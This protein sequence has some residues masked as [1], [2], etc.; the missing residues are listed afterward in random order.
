MLCR[1]VSAVYRDFPYPL[2]H[3]TGLLSLKKNI[4]EVDLKTLIGG[5]PLSLAGTIRNPGPNAIVELD[6]QAES[7]PVDDT[8]KKAVRPEVRKVLDQFN[9]SG[10]VKAHATVL[11]TPGQGAQGS[12]KDRSGS[13][14]ISISSSAARSPGIACLTRSET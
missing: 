9:P 4:L 11:R 2:D 12:R 10:L 14:P 3:L 6:I 13:T 7:L 1:D 5:G 8:L